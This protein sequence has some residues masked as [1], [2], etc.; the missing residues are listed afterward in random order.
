VILFQ[1]FADLYLKGDMVNAEETLFLILNSPQS[2]PDK[3][4]VAVYNNLG[5]INLM[6]GRYQKALEF[7]NRADSLVSA[8]DKNSKALADIYNNKAYIYNVQKSF[9]LAIEYLEK[10]IRIYTNLENSDETIPLSLSSVY[11][12]IGIAFLETRN[13]ISALEYFNKSSELKLKYKLPGLALTYLNFAK[14]YVKTGDHKKAGEFYLKSISVFKHEYGEDYFRLIDVNFDYGLF[15]R[16]IGKNSEALAIHQKALSICLKNYGEKHTLVSLAYKHIGDNYMTKADYKTALIYYQKALIAVVNDFNNQDINSNPETDHVIFD[17][18]LLDNLKSKSQALEILAEGQNDQSLKL[19]TLQKSFETIELALRLVDRI[20]N[21]Y[22]SQES[23]AYLAENEKETYI[24]ATYLAFSISSISHDQTIGIRMYDIAKKAKAVIIRKEITENDLLYSAGVPDSLRNKKSNLS[25]N[26]AGYNNL[27]IEEMRKSYPDNKKISLWKD[28][29]FNMNREKEKV[30]DKI[31]L[32]FPEYRYL[33]QKTEPISLTEIQEKLQGDETV[34]DYL[35]SNQYRN[36][37]RKLYTF[38]ITKEKMKCNETDL[39]S[40]FVKNAKVIAEAESSV[41]NNNFLEYTGALKYMH[42]K[43]IKSNKESF[44]GTRLYIIPDEEIAWLPFDAF[45]K[46]NPSENQTDYEGLQY[47]IN[48]YTFSYGY[49]SSLIFS[50]NRN[51][52]K[53]IDVFAFSP[54]YSSKND[55]KNLKYLQGADKEIESLFKWFDGKK[56]SGDQASE[57]NFKIAMKEPAVFHLALH[58]FSDSS[59]SRY[60]YFMFDSGKDTVEDSKLYN[61]EISLSRIISPMVVLSACNSGTGKLSHGEGIMSLARGFILAGASSVIKTAWEVN[62][63]SSASIISC[64]YKHL[65]KGQNKD[66]A[67]RYAKLEYLKSSQ[68]MYSHPY[69]WAAYE[70]MGDNSSITH[71]K[72]G[73]LVLI[74]IVVATI[75]AILMIIY[76]RRRRIFLA[77]SE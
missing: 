23:R 17:I 14:T 70:V 33:L 51:H 55:V 65:S 25:I 45:L 41:K 39:D 9:D 76:F 26:I 24:H 56:F 71:K 22:M 74:I 37:I 30:S 49:S 13:Y 7:N 44:A 58:A 1:R 67:L 28:A 77:R 10:S 69:Y 15:L 46:E 27:I 31:L 34:V 29:V 21:T 12:N 50:E 68:P 47:L 48:Y 60:S 18:R 66:E 32:E 35:L 43:L 57:S 2:I 20:R 73:S 19:K 11:M 3:H 61:Y 4:L 59:N 64:F 6:L 42:D 38:L 75:S 40:M 36:G 16:S 52:K 5:V 72:S 63:E 54:D 62:D 53:N 8:S